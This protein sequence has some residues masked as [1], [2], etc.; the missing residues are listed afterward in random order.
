MN[1]SELIAALKID[2]STETFTINGLDGI[3]EITVWRNGYIFKYIYS[4]ENNTLLPN[5]QKPIPN[6]DDKEKRNKLILDQH[7]KGKSQRQIANSLK[8]SQSTVSIVLSEVKNATP[9]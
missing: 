3:V 9:L 4:C 5:S 6:I 7:L 1:A 2:V 8:I